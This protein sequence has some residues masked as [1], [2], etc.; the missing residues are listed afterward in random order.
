MTAGSS[1]RGAASAISWARVRSVIVL[2]LGLV[3]LWESTSWGLL[4]V[5]A[6]LALVLLLPRGNRSLLAIVLGLC[7]I[8]VG[9]PAA[10]LFLPVLVPET[11]WRAGFRASFPAVTALFAICLASL[12][13]HRVEPYAWAAMTLLIGYL[14]SL[15]AALWISQIVRVSEQRQEALTALENSQAGLARTSLRLGVAQER[16]RVAQEIHDGVTQRLFVIRLLQEAALADEDGLAPRSLEMARDQTVQA[17][18]ELREFLEEQRSAGGSVE[19]R[20]LFD[21]LERAVASVAVGA[22]LDVRLHPGAGL[23]QNLP[24]TVAQTVLRVTREALNNVV[25]HANADTVDIVLEAHGPGMAVT[26][27]DNGVGMDV[28]DTPAPLQGHG[29]GL[30]GLRDRLVAEGGSLEIE[31]LVTG[32]LRLRAQVLLPGST[33]GG[34]PEEAV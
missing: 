5:A 32:G 7:L 6:G 25:A 4:F 15:V 30:S 2:L 21:D 17:L 23:P 18:R 12:L 1:G 13:G 24:G 11:Y 22:G 26:V 28:D 16:A 10:A 14:L 33:A 20:V 9:T 31:N 3:A 27:T 8:A 19:T 34:R 29:F